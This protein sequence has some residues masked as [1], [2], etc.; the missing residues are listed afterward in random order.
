VGSCD[1]ESVDRV[2]PGTSGPDLAMIQKADAE[3]WSPVIEAS[4]FKSQ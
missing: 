3:L 1:Q 2:G 4:G